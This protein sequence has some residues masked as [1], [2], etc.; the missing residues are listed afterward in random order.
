LPDCQSRGKQISK[1]PFLGLSVEKEPGGCGLRTLPKRFNG[2]FSSH[3]P[4]SRTLPPRLSPLAGGTSFSEA[5]Y[6]CVKPVI[7]NAGLGPRFAGLALDLSHFALL[8][9]ELRYL[10]F[11]FTLVSDVIG[12]MAQ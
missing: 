2:F 4:I 7:A 5:A 10:P 3:G 8:E 12:V 11:F 6:Y 9:A 1:V